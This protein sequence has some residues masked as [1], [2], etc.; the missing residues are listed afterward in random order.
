MSVEFERI[1]SETLHSRVTRSLAQ[2]VIRADRD[3]SPFEFPAEGEL[4]ELLG[5]SRTIVREALKVL[6][7]KGM[8]EIRP[9]SGMRS[10]PRANW[11]LLDP[12]IL[13][14][15]AEE[16][17]D[18]AFLRDLCE[19]RLALEP[20]AAGFAAVRASDDD[21]SE[22]SAALD[23]RIAAKNR[24]LD[25]IVDLDLQLHSAIVKASQNPFF[26]HLNAAIREPFRLALACTMHI[27]V[28]RNLD[29]TAHRK[30]VR[31]IERHDPGAARATADKIV[32]YAMLAVEQAARQE[33]RS[34]AARSDKKRNDRD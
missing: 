13:V 34:G 8:V 9:R 28:V 4:C 32:G 26:L 27:P 21:R 1:E 25:E 3:S 16:N 22:I 11:R 20:T 18:H 6:A 14:W 23:R 5:V 30:L 17:P 15:R 33:E 12:D 19:I 7:D 2:R 31:A 24:E 29:L 10:S